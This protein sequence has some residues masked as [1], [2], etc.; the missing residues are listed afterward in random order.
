[1][2]EIEAIAFAPGR[3]LLRQARFQQRVAMPSGVDAKLKSTLSAACESSVCGRRSFTK[4]AWTPLAA[5]Q[6][7][8]SCI[9]FVLQ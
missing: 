9:T 3:M 6:S 2:I 4:P 8:P 1:M 7:A 5:T